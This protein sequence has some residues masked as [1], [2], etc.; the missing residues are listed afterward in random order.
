MICEPAFFL[1]KFA[2]C[3]KTEKYPVPV[4]ND[5]PE[6]KA[7][8]QVMQGRDLL[9]IHSSCALGLC[10]QLDLPSNKENFRK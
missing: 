3:M 9:P 4:G 7:D 1:V 10:L 2:I 6:A 5:K 8:V